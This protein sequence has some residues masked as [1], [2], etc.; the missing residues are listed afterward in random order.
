MIFFEFHLFGG[1]FFNK[2]V[3]IPKQVSLLDNDELGS[4]EQLN[5]LELTPLPL[6]FWRWPSSPHQGAAIYLV[7]DRPDNMNTPILLYVG[8]TIAAEKRWKGE[9]DCKSY[10]QE[11]S[12]ACQKAGLRTQLSIR[13]WK[14]VPK[15]TKGR[16]AIEKQLI[17]KWLPAFNKETRGNWDTPFTNEI[18]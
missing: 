12:E 18:N 4:H 16:R 3:D 13:F 9:H 14:D 10:L 1:R 7:M 15:N 5:P 6:S 17:K 11:Y 2:N 8:E